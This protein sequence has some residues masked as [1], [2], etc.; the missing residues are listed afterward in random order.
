MF[1][2]YL[3]KISK[4]HYGN[5]KVTAMKGRYT[6]ENTKGTVLSDKVIYLIDKEVYRTFENWEKELEKHGID[7]ERDWFFNGSTT[8][9]SRNLEK[10]LIEQKEFMEKG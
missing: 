9:T 4:V 7:M 8:G 2:K 1:K 10:T 3:V 6:I 5:G